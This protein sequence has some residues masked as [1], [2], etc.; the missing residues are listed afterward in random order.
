[1]TPNARELQPQKLE[2]DLKITPEK[3]GTIFSFIDFGNVNHWFDRD[4]GLKIDLKKLSDFS[5]DFFKST[6]IYYGLDPLNK[7]SSNFINWMKI[8]FGKNYVYFKKIQKIKHY[9]DNSIITNKCNFDVEIAVDAIRLAN[10]YE[11]LCLFSGDADF[12]RLIKYLEQGEQKKII[13]IKGGFIQKELA[14]AVD[15]LI[16]AEDI[17]SLITHKNSKT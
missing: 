14:R 8:F 17:K 4:T 5:K 2:M 13:L 1:M 9:P 16:D 11:T 7:K 12:L 10:N 15:L 6:W 3:F